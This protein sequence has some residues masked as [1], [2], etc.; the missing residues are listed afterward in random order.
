[1]PNLDDAERVQRPQRLADGV[2]AGLQRLDQ[3]WFR[4]QVV[5]GAQSGVEDQPRDPL[6]QRFGHVVLLCVADN[7]PPP[8]YYV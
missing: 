8:T 4:R 3:P 7:I 1:V 6:L 2:T 5:T